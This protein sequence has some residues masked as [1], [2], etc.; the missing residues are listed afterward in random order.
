MDKKESKKQICRISIVG[1]GT[2]I[3]VTAI[4]EFDIST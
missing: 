4:I 2:L 1:A 3:C